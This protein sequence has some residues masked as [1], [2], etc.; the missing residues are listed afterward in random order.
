VVAGALNAVTEAKIAK[1]LERP[2]PAGARSLA[3]AAIRETF[4]ETGLLLGTHE[5]GPPDGTP[6]G[7]WQ[8]FANHGVYPDLEDLHFI[9]R[10]ITPPRFKKRFDTFFFAAEV[11]G[12]AARVE[13]KVGEACEL[14]EIAWV[15]FAQ[16]RTLGLA[17]ITN[18]LLYELEHRLAGGMSRYLPVPV[19]RA[20]RK[21]WLREEV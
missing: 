21:G 3:L 16:A 12:I 15:T 7:P 19:Y 20:G 17:S 18:V 14:V 13:G 10:A 6:A 5:F 4:E 9:G 2:S 8:E 11:S 1:C